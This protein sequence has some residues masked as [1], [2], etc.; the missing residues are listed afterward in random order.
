MND[1]L[2]TGLIALAVALIVT[3]VGVIYSSDRLQQQALT[4]GTSNITGDLAVSGTTTT[5]GLTSSATLAA[6]GGFSVDTPA[7]TVADTTGNTSIGSGTLTV[8]GATALDGGLTM[9]TNKFT[10]ANT[11][12]N[13]IIAGTLNVAGL[14]T[15]DDLVADTLVVTTTITLPANAL[16]AAYITNITRSVSIPLRSWLECTTDAGGVITPTDGTDAHPNL[17]NSA[18]NGLGFSL[19]FD[20][21]GGSVD[22][23]YVCSQIPVPRDY[24]SSGY[25]VFRATKGAETGANSEVLNCQGSINGAALGAAGT[26]TTSGTASA[27]YV[28]GP[29]LTALAAGDSLGLTFNITSGGTADDAVN[30]YSVAFEYLAIE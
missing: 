17:A 14:A 28:C 2:K 25:L 19:S 24:A 11:S 20:A 7:F 21:T 23:D 30:V 29:T 26:V 8:G 15:T 6:N 3:L 4:G 12:G 9:D 16:T 5:A 27:A 10:V 18:T 1:N 22:T 13:T